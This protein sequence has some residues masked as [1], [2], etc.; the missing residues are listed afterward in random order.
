MIRIAAAHPNLLPE[1]VLVE[2][3][4]NY[5]QNPVIQDIMA[6]SHVLL[7]HEFFYAKL[8][9]EEAFSH[10]LLKHEFFNASPQDPQLSHIK[11][12]T[13]REIMGYYVTSH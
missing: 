12:E 8:P 11:K 7:K 1:N 4:G 13:K 9:V 6:F 2:E 10:A 3:G 5:S